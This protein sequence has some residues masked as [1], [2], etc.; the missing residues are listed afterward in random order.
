MCG[1]FAI[2]ISG[3]EIRNYYNTENT[4]EFKPNYNITPLSNIPVIRGDDKIKLKIE[5]MQWGLVPYWSND[6]AIGNKLIN[7]RAE[8][9]Q[10]KPSFKKSFQSKRCIIPASGFYEWQDNTKQPFYIKPQNEILSFAGIWDEWKSPIGSVLRSCTIIT[11]EAN[12]KLHDIHHRMPV[13]L[14]QQGINLWLDFKTALS[15]L[16]NLLH[17]YTYEEFEYFKVDRRVNSPA[18]NDKGLIKKLT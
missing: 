17:P 14:D 13:I 5:L 18:N 7:A 12:Q 4:I 1:R 16:L 8:T 10:E 3:D 6:P 9:I 2:T 11:T 15:D